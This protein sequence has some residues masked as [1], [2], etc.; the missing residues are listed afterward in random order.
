LPAKAYELIEVTDANGILVKVPKAPQRIVT[1]SFA[2]TELIRLLG[3]ID[4]VVG[5]TRYVKARPEM[6]P[7]SAHIPDVGRG[8]MPDIETLSKLEPQLVV[9]WAGNPG[10]DLEEKLLPLGIHVLRL[11]FFL[12]SV[13]EREVN[14]LSEVMGDEAKEQA[15]KY[16]TWIEAHKT[17]I[18]NLIGDAGDKKTTVIIEH[19]TERR[20][21][22]PG[23]G[24]YELSL[25]A[26]A[27]N[28]GYYLGRQ[29]SEPDDE[30]IIRQNPDVYIK[31]VSP[32][33]AIS[34][35]ERLIVM[36]TTVREVME[37]PG[38]EEMDAVKNKRVHAMD[39]DFSGGPR[40]VIGLC[41]QA[42]FFYPEKVPRE[43][44]VQA[45]EEYLEFHKL[46][47]PK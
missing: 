46:K 30:W 29:S 26:G 25:L 4:H 16:L 45:F 1:L 36:E 34:E 33:I 10:P 12:P 8:F 41:Q 11:E 14:V 43:L 31:I 40:F 7:E 42:H 21:A 27:E 39:S 18:G 13:F 47:A 35:A 37:R 44:A 9:T 3:K 5:T 22:G 23:A 17:N 38:W 2:S 15:T 19:F 20:I 6:I 24:S 28:L 32:P